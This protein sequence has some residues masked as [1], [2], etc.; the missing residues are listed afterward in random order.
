MAWRVD[1][2]SELFGPNDRVRFW[3][4]NAG[5]V[6]MA[7]HAEEQATD[8]TGNPIGRLLVD[9]DQVLTA[10]ELHDSIVRPLAPSGTGEDE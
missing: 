8:D 4:A 10:V 3:Y 7:L 1:G 2:T 5:L 9:E 6:R